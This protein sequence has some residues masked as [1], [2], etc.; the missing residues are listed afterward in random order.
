MDRLTFLWNCLTHR[1]AINQKSP[2]RQ[3]KLLAWILLFLFLFSIAT[4]LV[5]R[6]SDPHHDPARNQYVMLIGSMAILLIFAYFLN[7]FQ[8]YQ[9]SAILL[10]S[11]AAIAPWAS[12]LI[13]P[14]ILQGDI[15]P[16]AY[17]TFSVLLSSIFLPTLFTFALTVLQLTGLILVLMFSPIDAS[18][19]WFSLLAF[20]FLTSIF[21][22]LANNIIQGDMKQ[23]INQTQQLQELVTHDDLTGLF[24]RRYLREM[25]EHEI[26]RTIQKQS[27]LCVVVLDIDNFK[28]IND[29]FGHA[30]G[31]ATLKELGS[32]LSRKVRQS[33][34]ASRYGGDE[35]ILVLPDM[36]R[37]AAKERVEHLRND[38][39]S[40]NL[41]TAIQISAGIA[42]FPENGMDGETLLKSADIALYKARQEGGNCVVVAE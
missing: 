20:V 19:N 28:H 2:H 13:D 26:Q 42:S 37:A 8:H 6:I 30:A 22:L 39:R 27:P 9:A 36:S 31:D 25:F 35:F 12:L 5:V 17:V 10:V 29:T 4:L 38:I 3:A 16:L 24:N 40:L 33:D 7:Y 41:Q 18:L 14:S 34:I 15:I 11:C 21:G 23:I 1:S 32:F